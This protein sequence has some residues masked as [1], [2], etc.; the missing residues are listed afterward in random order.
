MLYDKNDDILKISV[1]LPAYKTKGHILSVISLIGNEV[2]H[3]I[4]VDDACPLKTGLFVEDN[5]SDPRVKVLFNQRNMGVGGA[6][7]TGYKYAIAH[8]YD[9]AIKIDSD[10]QMNPS[11]IPD[12]LRPLI[13]NGI[14]Y[15]KGNRFFRFGDLS[16]MP[17]HRI[18]GNACLSFLNKFASGYWHIFDPTNGYTAVKVSSL[19]KIDLDKIDKRYFFESDMLYHLG[20][21]R[22]VVKDIPMVAVYADEVSGLSAWKNL[23]PFIW[24]NFRNSIKRIIYQYYLRDFSVASLELLLGLCLTFG[25]VTIGIWRWI[26]GLY[27]NVSATGG[28]VMLA[29]LPIIIGVQ[30]LISFLNFDIMN[31]PK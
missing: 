21:S 23:F 31:E 13:K 25:G 8:D 14:D 20:L 30:F 22:A 10:G 3:I 19:K 6:M 24:K 4:V 5:C 18:I 28:Q 2:Q 27:L 9:I 1:I 17:I 26:D 7:V 29:A 12:F 11:L 15:V 16:G